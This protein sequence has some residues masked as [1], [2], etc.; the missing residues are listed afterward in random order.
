MFV[1]GLGFALSPALFSSGCG[2]GAV[3]I[4]ACRK[5][6]DARCDA[7]VACGFTKEQVSDCKLFYQDQCL[8]GIE[9]S[10]H[11][12]S[13][14]EVNNCI[15]AVNATGA[16]ATAQVKTMSAC[17]DAPVSDDA[18]GSAPCD[19]LLSTAQKLT[20]CAF[21]EAPADAG[22]TTSS[23]GTGGT[24]SSTGG[25]GGTTGT[26]GSAGTAGSQ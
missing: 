18:Q 22:T 14:T 23:G 15:A 17:A 7:A 6:E 26:S 9:N 20:A 3:G 2:S 24:T 4:E 25:T 12:P 13:E 5:I 10:A 19:V 1:A 16:C 11:R 21:A 8:H